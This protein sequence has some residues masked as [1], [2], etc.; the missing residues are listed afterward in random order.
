M[1]KALFSLRLR[2]QLLAA[3]IEDISDFGQKQG[4]NIK[5]GCAELITVQETVYSVF[6][7]KID[8]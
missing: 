1:H 7:S 5:S 2:N 6:V 4:Q 3:Y 8:S